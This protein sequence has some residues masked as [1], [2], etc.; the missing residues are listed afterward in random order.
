MFNNFIKRVFFLELAVEWWF[1]NFLTIQQLGNTELTRVKTSDWIRSN[2][3]VWEIIAFSLSF[4][5]LFNWITI[6]NWLMVGLFYNY[7]SKLF[8]EIGYMDLVGKTNITW[9]NCCVNWLTTIY[10]PMQWVVV[11][12]PNYFTELTRDLKNF[13][14]NLLVKL[15]KLKV[16]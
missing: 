5:K 13:F 16:I 12:W 3:M 4:F 14:V 15:V 8:E 9:L 7:V 11:V 1:G 6:L 2:W 10:K